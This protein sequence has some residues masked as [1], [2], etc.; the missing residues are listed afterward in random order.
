MAAA[1]TNDKRVKARS[2]VRRFVA[3]F[4]QSITAPT[5]LLVVSL[6][7]MCVYIYLYVFSHFLLGYYISTLVDGFNAQSPRKLALS[8]CATASAAANKDMRINVC[9]CES[10]EFVGGYKGTLL[11]SFFRYTSGHYL[12]LFF[13]DWEYVCAIMQF[14]YLD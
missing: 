11:L 1:T 6:L 10:F 4:V 12:G 3:F 13:E 9:M 5:A 14:D 2:S 8:G 7:Y